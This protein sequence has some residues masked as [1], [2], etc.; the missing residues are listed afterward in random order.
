MGG[1]GNIGSPSWSPVGTPILFNSDRTGQL[2]LYAIDFEGRIRHK[3]TF[4]EG[5]EFNGVWRPSSSP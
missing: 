4:N 2:E 3:F 1:F 5:N